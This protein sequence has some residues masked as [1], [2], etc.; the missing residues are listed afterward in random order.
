MTLT[1]LTIAEA[2]TTSAGAQ[3]RTERHE[4][5]PRERMTWLAGASDRPRL[6]VSISAGTR[7]DTLG[8]LVT[9]VTEGGA[10]AKAGIE[11][12]DRL[13]SIGSVSLRL[14]P[15]DAG[16]EDMAGVAQRRLIRELDRHE[17]GDEVELR[18]YSNGQWKTLKATLTAPAES[19]FGETVLGA[20]R[21]SRSNRAVLGLSFGMS[22]SRRDTLG[23]MVSSVTDDGPADKAGIEEGDRIVAING[24]DLRVPKEDAGDWS[25]SSLRARRVTRE[26][27]KVKVGDAVDLRVYRD[28]QIRTVSVTTIKAADLPDADRS[29]FFG[30]GMEGLTLPRIAR[31]PEA[32]YPPEAP[33]IPRTP[34]RP[35]MFRWDDDGEVRLRLDPQLRSDIEDGMRGLERGMIEL[36]RAIPRVRVRVYR[37]IDESV[38]SP[39]PEPRLRSAPAFAGAVVS[40]G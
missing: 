15:E 25:A 23:I 38:G 8:L 40:A 24:V 22:G 32:P 33:G 14:S 17:A 36:R 13:A 4:R 21:E 2:F 29:F 12:G 34:R 27:E 19:A 3:V 11:E 16:E 28:G 5:E 31:P 37:D 9:G 20:L 1:L 10:A 30:D 6:G 35:M 7:R 26:L 18:V 39:V